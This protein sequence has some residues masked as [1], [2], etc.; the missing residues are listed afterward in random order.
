MSQ[1]HY[2]TKRNRRPVKKGKA[3]TASARIAETM[4]RLKLLE[5]SEEF[6]AHLDESFGMFDEVRVDMFNEHGQYVPTYK[7]KYPEG[8]ESEMDLA[9]NRMMN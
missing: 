2:V 8:Q 5:A 3:K 9:L 4:A 6:N 1:N 7:E